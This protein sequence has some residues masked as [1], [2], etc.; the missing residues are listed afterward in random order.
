MLAAP[1]L[2]DIA[3]SLARPPRQSSD[4][5]VGPSRILCLILRDL[6]SCGSSYGRNRTGRIFYRFANSVAEAFLKFSPHV[7]TRLSGSR[8]GRDSNLL[9]FIDISSTVHLH[10]GEEGLMRSALSLARDL[11]FSAQCAVADTPSG[12]QA[13][14]TAH[15]GTI[16]PLGEERERLKEL[17]LPLLLNLEGLQPWMKPIA[18]EGIVTFFLMLG[19]KT[20]DDLS[21]FTFASFHERWGE[22]GGLLWK[23]LNAQDDQ[24]LNEF[25]PSEQ[26]FD[27]V[28]LDFSVSL[29]SLLL[30]QMEKSIDILFA[31]LAG[32]RRLAQKL[33]ITL[34]NDDSISEQIRFE[35]QPPHASRHRDTFLALIEQQLCEL[36]MYP[37][38]RSFRIEVVGAEDTKALF[39]ILRLA[40]S[41]ECDF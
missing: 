1:S 21:R 22:A 38:I 11:G 34:S 29:V 13:F 36:N 5:F 39:E 25:E 40:D 28:Q 8:S 35:T 18:I 7:F 26:I 37:S 30:H 20:I 24:D 27:F 19:F 33:I 41:S 23:R 6:S 4:H 9:V 10:H 2:Q 15:H 16:V 3:S 14:A 17:S 32:R 31:R 12:A